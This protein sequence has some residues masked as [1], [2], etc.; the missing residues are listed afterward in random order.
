MMNTREHLIHMA[1]Q[2]FRNFA[3][4]GEAAAVEATAEHILLYWDPHMKAQALEMLD[5]PDVELPE[6]VPAVFEKLRVAA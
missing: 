5:D 2:I 3:S 1:G 4:K 6:P